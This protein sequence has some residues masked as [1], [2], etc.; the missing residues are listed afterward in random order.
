MRAHEYASPLGMNLHFNPGQI[1]VAYKSVI[2]L[3][4]LILQ[5]EL[6]QFFPSKKP[7]NINFYVPSTHLGICSTFLFFYPKGK[8][9]N[10]IQM[11]YLLLMRRP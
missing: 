2:H 8:W 10:I 6:F 11:K 5:V 1:F 7:K 4:N 3:F 9:G